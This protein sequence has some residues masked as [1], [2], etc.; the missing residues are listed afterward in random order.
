[1]PDQKN[2]TLIERPNHRLLD[3]VSESTR[4]VLYEARNFRNLKK[5]SWRRL[6]D[7]TGVP[8]TTLFGWLEEGRRVPADGLERLITTLKLPREN[9]TGAQSAVKEGFEVSVSIGETTYRL[10][11]VPKGRPFEIRT[12]GRRYYFLPRPA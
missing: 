7:V 6:S 9:S 12:R 11:R 3:E 5:M 4:R 8:I 1:M 10:V 2:K